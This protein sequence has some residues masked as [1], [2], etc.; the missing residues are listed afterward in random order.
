M[1]RIDGPETI[2]YADRIQARKRQIHALT[3]KLERVTLDCEKVPLKRKA[4]VVELIRNLVPAT[5]LSFMEIICLTVLIS[6]IITM[7]QAGGKVTP[8]EG[9]VILLAPLLG[10]YFGVYC[11][12]YWKRVARII[13][14]LKDLKDDEIQYATKR[15]ILTEKLAECRGELEELCNKQKNI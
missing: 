6:T 14:Y 3:T 9:L 13:I 7:V 15:I 1:E 11:G 2:E 5:V 4:A 8:M 12:M 10:I